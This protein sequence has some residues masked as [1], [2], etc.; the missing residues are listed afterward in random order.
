MYAEK[1]EIDSLIN[2]NL[3][4][5]QR[6]I[7]FWITLQFTQLNSQVNG[8]D[9]SMKATIFENDQPLSYFIQILVAD[10]K[11]ICTN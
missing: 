8:I 3:V 5:L 11:L 1:Y 4:G 7:F 10:G 6:I 9:R 2:Q